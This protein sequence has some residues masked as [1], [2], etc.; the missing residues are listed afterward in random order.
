M[1]L[2]P[3][4]LRGY[5]VCRDATEGCA[6]ACLNTAGRGGLL[7]RGEHTNA[8]QAARVRRTQLFFKDRDQFADMLWADLVKLTTVAAWLG[9]TPCFR[10][11]GTSDLP[12]EKIKLPG[13]FKGR[14]MMEAFGGMQFYDYTKVPIEKRGIGGML[15]PNYDLTYSMNEGDE[16]DYRAVQ[17]LEHGYRAAAVFRKVLPSHY[18]G[19]KVVPGDDHDLTFT[20]KPCILGLVA[21]GKG[22]HDTSG[23][24]LD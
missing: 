5:Q 7:K 22:I 12:L 10:G 23:F 2:A 8:I 4:D 3:C 21:K 20:H 16:S 15:P 17:Y 14:T 19:I 11:N 18:Y 24:V 1:H 13:A 6:S 9:L